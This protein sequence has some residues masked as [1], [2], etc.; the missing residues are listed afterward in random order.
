[1]SEGA[2]F[3][4]G[5]ISLA[6]ESFKREKKGCILLGIIGA[7]LFSLVGGILWFFL[8]QLGF[9]VEF[10]GIITAICAYRGYLLFAG[11]NHVAGVLLALVISFCVI[12]MAWFLS[13]NFDVYTDHIKWY[14]EGVLDDPVSYIEALSITPK[15]LVDDDLQLYYLKPLLSGFLLC[16]IG[17]ILPI[18]S[19]IGSL[20]ESRG[21]SPKEV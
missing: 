21:D 6:D 20:R 4:K 1:M 9:F 15:Y 13:I 5:G 3:S 10:S 16:A 19:L 14:N 11:K 2:D 8:Y 17:W 7:F 18:R 12:V